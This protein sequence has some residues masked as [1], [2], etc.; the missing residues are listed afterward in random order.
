M[1]VFLCSRCESRERI[2]RGNEI[3]N[4]RFADWTYDEVRSLAEYQRSYWF[5][6]FV[7]AKVH[8]PQATPKGLHCGQCDFLLTWAYDWTLDW[9][10]KKFDDS[11]G[12]GLM[13]KKPSPDPLGAI[14][15]ALERP[16]V[17]EKG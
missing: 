10:W 12:S 2:Y 4:R 11:G 6:P 7:C 16:D 13:P 1:P 14:S 9:T 15:I 8:L 3:D 5:L 17:P